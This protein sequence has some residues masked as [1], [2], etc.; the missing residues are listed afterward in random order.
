[1]NQS[2][3]LLNQVQN[4]M[5]CVVSYQSG[6]LAL[7]DMKAQL[8]SSEEYARQIGSKQHKLAKKLANVTGKLENKDQFKSNLLAE[9]SHAGIDQYR[10]K[11][12][13]DNASIPVQVFILDFLILMISVLLSFVFGSFK[14]TAMQLV[15]GDSSQTLLNAA[16]IAPFVAIFFII[17]RHKYP[18]EVHRN[19]MFLNRKL[20]V[21]LFCVLQIIAGFIIPTVMIRNFGNVQ[22]AIA[23]LFPILLIASFIITVPIFGKIAK[24]YNSRFVQEQNKH[25]A[26]VFNKGLKKLEEEQSELQSENNWLLSVVN[27]V[28]NSI[29]Q[30]KNVQLPA[31]EKEVQRLHDALP[32]KIKVPDRYLYDVL[33][34]QY[35]VEI[36]KSDQAKEIGEAHRIAT[37][38]W[39]EQVHHNE[40]HKDAETIK[41]LVSKQMDKQDV[42]L[43][44]IMKEFWQ[45]NTS[46]QSGFSDASDRMR[47]VEDAINGRD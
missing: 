16:S 35:L 13:K 24:K 43:E 38:R 5:K 26:V 7:K 3:E 17:F 47:D 6:L 46:V 14:A 34:Y 18:K 20:L 31:A 37:D 30:M 10:P 36:V 42:A 40:N 45:L 29:A 12:K 9:N 11:I 28:D 25:D 23:I 4:E 21:R 19:N 1:M 39:T 15:T 44:G 8:N 22:P 33:Y 32:G 27:D 2:D 41:D